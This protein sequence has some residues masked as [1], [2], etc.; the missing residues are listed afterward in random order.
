MPGN[1]TCKLQQGEASYV[2]YL[3]KWLFYKDLAKCKEDKEFN[4]TINSKWKSCVKS[5]GRK[6]WE[7]IEWNDKSKNVNYD[8][9]N[10]KIIN[11]YFT[12]IF[13]NKNIIGNPT[14][15][16]IIQAVNNYDI[17]MPILD[18]VITMDEMNNAIEEIGTGVGIDGLYP[19]LTNIFTYKLK[20]SLVTFVN[21]IHGQ[22]VS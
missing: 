11:S 7:L 9:I 5:N 18:D 2:N 16:D 17:Y 19:S 21:R 8:T 22:D 14:I 12:N 10:P 13:Q 3:D 6:L 15:Q 20:L 1:S 4:T